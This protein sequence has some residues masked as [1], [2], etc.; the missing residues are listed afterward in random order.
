MFSSCRAVTVSDRVDS[1]GFARGASRCSPTTLWAPCH[2]R[3]GRD[4]G[5]GGGRFRV[6]RSQTPLRVSWM[7]AAEHVRESRPAL[8][9]RLL[10]LRSGRGRLLA[11]CS[12]AVQET[13]VVRVL[14]WNLFHGRAVP[15]AGRPLL[16]EYATTV[17]GWEG[18]VA[19]L[20][21]VPPWWPATL[22]AASGAEFRAVLTSR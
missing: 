10:R 12:R 3:L 19:L 20:Q 2:R 1:P 7:R 22:A 6:A 15:R 18:D 8:R 5:D 17:A 14:I 21:E 9:M 11:A 4:G 16:A 13:A